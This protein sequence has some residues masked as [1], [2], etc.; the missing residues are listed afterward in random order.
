MMN[1][2]KETE[3]SRMRFDVFLR[4]LDGEFTLLVYQSENKHKKR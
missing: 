1:R 3:I 4:S 2:I